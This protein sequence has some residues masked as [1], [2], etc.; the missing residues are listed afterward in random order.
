MSAELPDA[1]EGAD[2]DNSINLVCLRQG[3]RWSTAY[4]AAHKNDAIQ[5]PAKH[6]VQKAESHEGVLRYRLLASL[7]AW[8]DSIA[9][10]LHRQHVN[11]K[12]RP[13]HAAERVATPEILGITV[14]EENG[15]AGRG[16]LHQQA[17]HEVFR[18]SLERVQGLWNPDE[19]VFE[20]IWAIGR[21]G[22]GEKHPRDEVEA[23]ET[24][25]C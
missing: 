18:S 25:G 3:Q 13:E 11:L 15:E 14:A 4:R 23:G 6:L 1:E 5:G 7:P 17:G 2:D 9:R 16:G 22:C 19:F 8:T 21:L 20:V 10:V 24:H 12:L